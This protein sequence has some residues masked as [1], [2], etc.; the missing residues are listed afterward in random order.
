MG[1]RVEAASGINSRK[2]ALVSTVAS[3]LSRLLQLK[4]FTIYFLHLLLHQQE[5]GLYLQKTKSD[6]EE[7]NLER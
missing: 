2:G 3:L 4:D 1:H 7:E 6:Y 5:T